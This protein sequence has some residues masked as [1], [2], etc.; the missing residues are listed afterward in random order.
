[1]FT[2]DS[3]ARFERNKLALW[4]RERTVEWLQDVNG[5]I[6]FVIKMGTIK[7]SQ[8]I[9]LSTHILS[10]KFR[11]QLNFIA[12]NWKLAFNL[13][14]VECVSRA[15]LKPMKNQKPS[16]R[17]SC[18]IERKIIFNC[19]LELLVTYLIFLRAPINGLIQTAK[20]ALIGDTKMKMSFYKGTI[21]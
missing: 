10:D 17:L 5:G 6:N 11:M 20:C 14:S 12:S 13:Q 3:W 8:N 2:C 9:I 19:F 15:T 1:M 16:K 21:Y 18:L 4:K 7:F